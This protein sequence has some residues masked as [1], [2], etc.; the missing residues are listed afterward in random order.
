MIPGFCFGVIALLSVADVIHK[1][2][3]YEVVD[4]NN[5]ICAVCA[6]VGVLSTI[7]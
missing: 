5:C 6:I 2:Q 4:V 1:V 3:L 7:F